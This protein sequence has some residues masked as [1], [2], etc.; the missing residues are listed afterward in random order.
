MAHACANCGKTEEGLKHCAKC[1]SEY[2]CS[3]DCQKAHWK[4]HK[5]VCA[6]KAASADRTSSASTSNTTSTAAPPKNLTGA[7]AQ[8]FHRLHAR[9]WLHD[10]PEEDVYKLLIDTCRLRLDDD[11]KLSQ[12]NTEG[13]VFAG[14]PTSLPAFRR[15]LALAESRQ[16][17]LPDWWSPEKRAACVELGT[18]DSDWYSL[19][20]GPEKSDFNE[21]YGDATMAMQMRMFGEQVYGTGPGG[22]AGAGMMQMMMAHERE[23]GRMLSVLSVSSSFGRG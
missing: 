1:S 21:H 18:K 9:A 6:A 7:V 16:G 5:K 20:F 11:Y 13:S 12:L 14:A 19:C 23:A 17:L 8:P 4:T 22:E 3:R 2:Y 10:R 15:F